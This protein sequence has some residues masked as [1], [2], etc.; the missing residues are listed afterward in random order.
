MTNKNRRN[1]LRYPGYDYTSCGAYYVT[2]CTKW[3]RNLFGQVV[4][5]EMV[6]NE[7]GH[8][9]ESCWLTIPDHHPHVEL[10]EHVIMPNHMHGTLNIVSEIG[11]ENE[12]EELA[13]SS[14]EDNSRAGFEIARHDPVVRK[15]GESIAGSLSTILGSYKAAVSRE[16]N[17]SGLMPER[18]RWHR[19]F[20]DRIVR[21]DRALERYRSYMRANPARWQQDKLHPSMPFNKFNKEWRETAEYQRHLRN[22]KKNG[23]NHK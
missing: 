14:V 5:Q 4:N 19:N 11:S 6:L 17:R 18:M 22:H 3:G 13:L 20:W 10:D 21:H 7:V 1:S 8:I 12:M 2:I 23:L 16:V 15:F 9:A